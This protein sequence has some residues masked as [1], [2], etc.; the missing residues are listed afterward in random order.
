[1]RCKL[2]QNFVDTA[3]VTEGL[4]R[5]IFW[6]LALPGFGLMV[7]RNGRRSYVIQYKLN[8]ISRRMT[9]KRGLKLAEARKEALGVIGRV[10]KGIDVLEDER[11]QRREREDSFKSIAENY[12]VRDA[13]EL[14]SL[15]QKKAHLARFLYP[16]FGDR[17][18]DTIKRSEIVRLMDD[19]EDESGPVMADRVLSTL[20][21]IM[22]WHA[23]RSDD[24]VL[25]FVRGMSRGHSMSRSRTLDDGE[26]RS[27]W[28][29]TERGELFDNYIRFLF[30]TCVRRNEAA[31]ATW[32]EFTTQ[33]GRTTWL[34]PASRYKTKEELLL[35][36]SSAASAILSKLPRINEFVF[37]SGRTP[38]AGFTIFMNDLK[39][40]SGTVGWSI[41]DIRR[42]GRSL[43]SRAKVS[44]D[45]G[46]RCLGHAMGNIRKTYDRHTYESEKRDAFEALAQLIGFIINNPMDNFS[47]NV[48]ALERA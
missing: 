6:D 41:H 23:G 3:T 10:A 37:T 5:E 44:A 16:R 25:P 21:R 19:I 48:V 24:F 12:L 14:R 22:Q 17:A 45:I 34:I 15:G 32:D 28:A 31:R 30:L 47:G 1:M 7:T 26:I 18:I 40:R 35:P 33:R 4:E 36:L 2:T 20:R 29:A 27:I 46:E 43:L 38:I 42:T 9:L 8:G 39:K 13:K 11:K